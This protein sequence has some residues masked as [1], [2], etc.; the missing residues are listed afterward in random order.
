MRYNI[1]NGVENISIDKIVE[2]LKN[3]NQPR[4]ELVELLVQTAIKNPPTQEQY[5]ALYYYKGLGYDSI[6]S[7]KAIREGNIQM[8][9]FY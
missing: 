4:S 9:R 7:G 5:N 2:N 3:A 6:N 8:Q 1:L